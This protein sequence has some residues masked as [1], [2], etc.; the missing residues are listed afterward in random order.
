MMVHQIEIDVTFATDNNAEAMVIDNEWRLL[1]HDEAEGLWCSVE[2]TELW[3]EID[4]LPKELKM[5]AQDVL[6][7]GQIH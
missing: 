2:H 4:M 7:A 5:R 1:L 6:D 3:T